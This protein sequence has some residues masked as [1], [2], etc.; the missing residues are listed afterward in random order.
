MNKVGHVM[1][2]IS[3]VAVV[4]NEETRIETF[5]KSFLWSNDLIIIDK[6]STDATRNIIARY[7]QIKLI[8]TDYSDTGGEARLGVECAKNEWIMTLTAS[9]II[10]PNLVDKLLQYINDDSFNYD[11]I[12]LPF[13]IYVFGIRD[14]KRSPWCAAHKEWMYKKN[15]LQTSNTA[16]QET[17]HGSKNI[18]KMPYSDVENLYHLTHETMDS[19]LERHIRYTRFEAKNYTDEKNA[20]KDS[21]KDF[22]KSL[23]E[24]CYKR[25]SFLKGWDGVALGLAYISY[26]IL[27][28]LFVWQKFRGHGSAEYQKIRAEILQLW[29]REIEK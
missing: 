11:V 26:F 6:S 16:H 7:P 5:I 3:V 9:N 22:L 29:D 14:I 20:L 21:F 28:F 10:H 2:N 12:A 25:K 27:K 8:V 4:Y 24:V 18:Y 1:K 17:Y 23:K 19:F 15:I 13:A